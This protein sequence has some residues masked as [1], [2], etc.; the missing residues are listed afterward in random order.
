MSFYVKTILPR[1]F[2]NVF[3]KQV[4]KEYEAIA[5]DIQFDFEQT[6]Q[7]WKNEP[8]WERIV[9][10]QPTHIAVLVGTDDP[11]FQYVDKGTRPHDIEGKKTASNPSGRLAFMTTGFQA[12][13][14]PESLSSSYGVSAGP[15]LVRPQ[16]VHHP[17]TKPRN[18]TKKIQKSWK[19]KLKKR[20]DPFVKRAAKESGH[21]AR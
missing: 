19:E 9:D 10:I 2:N 12:K 4:Q 13:T 14:S 11:I 21:G 1:R 6:T 17:G 20:I 7:T 5:K 15:P 18:F 3:L 8:K 16:V